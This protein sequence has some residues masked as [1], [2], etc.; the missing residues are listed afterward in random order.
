M[1]A[2]APDPPDQRQCPPA[3]SAHAGFAPRLPP[4]SPARVTS[5]LT[6]SVHATA[7]AIARRDGKRW[8]RR[9]R[10]RGRRGAID[11]PGLVTLA[12]QRSRQP[13]SRTS[14]RARYTFGQRRGPHP[15]SHGDR[16]AAATPPWCRQRPP[17]AG[18]EC[19][20]PPRPR[21]GRRS[22][23]SA[24][25]PDGEHPGPATT[26]VDKPSPLR[27]APLSIAD[28]ATLYPTLRALQRRQ[29]GR[30]RA[31]EQRRDNQ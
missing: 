10:R 30:S 2:T 19:G 9:D 6:L 12:A 8:P 18:P 24:A 21:H 23:R 11:A 4:G 26:Q 22:G 27:H 3:R 28:P 7:A 25:L 5:P 16:P 14:L 13:A 31:G 1:A 29:Q 20:A 15:T 17:G